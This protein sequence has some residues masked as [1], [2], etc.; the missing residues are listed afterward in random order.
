VLIIFTTLEEMLEP[1]QLGLTIQLLL[2]VSIPKSTLV[3]NLSMEPSIHPSMVVELNQ[4]IKI[5]L[6]PGSQ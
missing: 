5:M 4:P 3:M 2:T 6:M 1:P